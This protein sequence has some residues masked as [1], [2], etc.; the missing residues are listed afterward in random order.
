MHLKVFL[1][2]KKPLKLSLLGKYIKKNKKPKKTHW[3]G[4][5]LNL[6]F[7]QPCLSH[8]RQRY[9]WTASECSM[10]VLTRSAIS[11]AVNAFSQKLQV[12]VAGSASP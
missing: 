10:N 6:G 11:T 2:L 9:L 8:W 3:A 7:F 5:F 12:S 4:F 1:K